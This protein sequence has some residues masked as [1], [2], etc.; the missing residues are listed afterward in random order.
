MRSTLRLIAAAALGLP[1]ISLAG[2]SDYV[3][4]PSVEYGEREIDFK[5]GTAKLAEGAGRESAGSFGVGWGATQW[6]FTEAYIKYEKN[7]GEST[8][9]DAFEWENKFQL[10][11]TGRYFV[12]VGLV[13]EIEI[14]RKHHE[15]GYELMA[16]PLF[17]WDTGD[18]RWNANLLFERIVGGSSDE[19]RIT[20]MGYQAQVK[21]G[22]RPE[23]EYGLQA[24][25]D[26]G[27]WNHWE[28]AS[29]QEHRAGP[30]I[31]GKVKLGPRQT[32]RYNAA[33]LFG[34][35]KAAADNTF[36]MQVEYEF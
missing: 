2:P 18:L 22:T 12:D 24:F 27:K 15:E 5:Y 3:I 30:A 7:P 28:P 26:M 17:Q 10:T 1:G 33:L 19:P 20:E 9:Y 4:T 29:E 35:T 34:L 32:I 16:G 36:R 8:R 14:P 6:W 23:L 31:F 11:Q 25:G 21:Y 13:A